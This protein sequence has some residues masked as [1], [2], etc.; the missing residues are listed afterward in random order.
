MIPD[1]TRRPDK[2]SSLSGAFINLILQK[3]TRAMD[4]DRTSV[5]FLHSLQ[6]DY[7]EAWYQFDDIYVPLIRKWL[8]RYGMRGSD[9]EDI[10]Q[11]VLVVVLRKLRGFERR[12]DGSF[13]S[14]LR[15]ITVNCLRDFRRK[16]WRH[17]RPGGGDDFAEMLH[18]LEDPHSSLRR[19][20]DT[21]HD[22]HVLS[23]A[24]NE[25]KPK[26]TQRTWQAFH[27][28]AIEG[29]T[30]GEVASELGISE[31]AVCIAKSRVCSRIRDVVK[32]LLL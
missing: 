4:H 23:F 15:Q 29:K 5:D 8:E 3:A 13:R 17:V 22:L 12:R 6:Q 16:H 31:N 21:E 32:E 30:P 11:E 19:F 14:W 2:R 9:A 28:T 7:G 18:S 10:A 24:M 26:F 25:L 27:G 20:W 1:Q